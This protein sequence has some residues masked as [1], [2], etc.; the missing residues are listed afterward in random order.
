MQFSGAPAATAASRMTIA[1]AFED[2]W[3]FGWKA[4]M[5]GLRVLMQ[6]KDLKMT[7]EVGL[8][9]G[10]M[11]QTTPTGS[12]ISVMPFDRV[13]FDD[14][15]RFGVT[16]IVDDVFASE[17]VLGGFVFE[18]AAFGLFDGFAGQ[19]T[20][21]IEASHR[22]LGDDEVDFLLVEGSEF[23]QGFQAFS[24]KRSLQLGRAKSLQNRPSSRIFGSLKRSSRF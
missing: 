17:E 22:H 1:A 20:M 18:D 4:K 21:V 24:T 19:I 11:P 10:V 13:F 12:A 8:V 2:S 14:A 6:I 3:A 16:H 15:H 9:T 7:V 23:G 5:I